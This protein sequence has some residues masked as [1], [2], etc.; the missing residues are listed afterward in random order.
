[1]YKLLMAA[2][3]LATSA[4]ALGASCRADMVGARGRV[5]Q[6][7]WGQGYGMQQACRQ[8]QRQCQRALHWR[9]EHGYNPYA[10]CTVRWGGGGGGYPPW[11]PGY[12]PWGPGGGGGHP[13]WGPG[14]GGPGG[15]N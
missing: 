4:T 12:P 13:P 1:M 2:L 11:G 14:H 7:F 5:I 9:Q 8:A 6:S 15:W 3:C 10:R